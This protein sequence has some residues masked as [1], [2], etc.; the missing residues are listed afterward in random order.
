[1]TVDE[2]MQHLKETGCK[3][4]PQRRMLIEVLVEAGQQPLTAD[5]VYQQIRAIYP[6][7]GLDTVYRNLRL[8]VRLGLVDEVKLP[9]KLAEYSLTRE[10]HQHGLTCLE[11][12]KEIPLR[13]CP[14]KELE[15]LARTE[16][17]FEISSHRIE[18]FGYCADCAAQRGRGDRN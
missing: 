3:P 5:A 13:H 15:T 9:G 2:V 16:H 12:G 10:V 7:V 14:I 8:L 18:L 17:G 4:T 6:D 11:C 1:M